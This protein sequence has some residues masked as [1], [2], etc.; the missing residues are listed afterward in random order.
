MDLKVQISECMN[1][2]AHS[3]PPRIDS[4]FLYFKPQYGQSYC[5]ALLSAVKFKG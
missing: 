5:S 2:E 3:A 4:P 1:A